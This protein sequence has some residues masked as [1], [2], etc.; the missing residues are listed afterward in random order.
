MSSIAAPAPTFVHGMAF[1]STSPA[2]RHH[3]GQHGRLVHPDASATGG[4]C[5]GR[6]R[7][8]QRDAA[9]RLL[10]AGAHSALP[11]V[12]SFTMRCARGRSIRTRSSRRISGRAARRAAAAHAASRP[13]RL[14]EVLPLIGVPARHAGLHDNGSAY[15]SVVVA[16]PSAY[17]HTGTPSSRN[18]A[19]GSPTPSSARPRHGGRTTAS[20]SRVRRRR[21]D[22]RRTAHRHRCA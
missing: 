22:R 3:A 11:I 4:R 21:R 10:G 5:V 9:Q 8:W 12:G 6:L 1:A 19:T 18:A 14:A 7:R 20:A 17:S 15:R 13:V 16:C 2:R